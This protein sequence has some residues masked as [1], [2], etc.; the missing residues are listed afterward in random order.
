MECALAACSILRNHL[1]S[2]RGTERPVG[3][4]FCNILARVSTVYC[5][6][7][8]TPG[9]PLRY[10]IPRINV[11]L[12]Q[13]HYKL[14]FLW[15]IALSKDEHLWGVS[16][17]IINSERP[18]VPKPLGPSMQA[19]D[20]RA[21][22]AARHRP[23]GR[24]RSRRDR[25]QRRTSAALDA[26]PNRPFVVKREATPAFGPTN[27]CQVSTTRPYRPAAFHPRY[28]VSTPI[29]HRTKEPFVR[30]EISGRLFTPSRAHSSPNCPPSSP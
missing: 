27:H 11:V 5:S 29:R 18:I 3:Q 25:V 6:R 1:N 17:F 19:H 24:Q 15:R 23:H 10:S 28:T 7:V 21:P 12:G 13:L 26:M 16:P 22:S 14:L 30:I 4:L 9:L 20:E 8:V 2:H